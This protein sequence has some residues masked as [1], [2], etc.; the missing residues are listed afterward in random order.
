MAEVFGDPSLSRRF[1]S[2]VAACG[3]CEGIDDGPRTAPSKRIEA[4]FPGYLK[5]RSDFAHGPRIAG[6]L[7]LAT[8]R[9]RCPRFDEWLSR[10]E[11][12]AGP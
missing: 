11:A 4:I 10:L 8:V 9:D 7:N 5:G 6:R 12:L 3:G 2:I 1:E